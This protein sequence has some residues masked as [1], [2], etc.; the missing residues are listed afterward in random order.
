[1]PRRPGWGQQAVAVLD[2]WLN[3]KLSLPGAAA[4]DLSLELLH[5]E[6]R[7]KFWVAEEQQK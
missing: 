6:Y 2:Q 1:M 5:K 3:A 4:N 7:A